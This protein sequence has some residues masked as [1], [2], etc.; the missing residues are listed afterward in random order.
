MHVTMWPIRNSDMLRFFYLQLQLAAE[1]KKS[2]KSPKSGGK[3]KQL[4]GE[5]KPKPKKAT[6]SKPKKVLTPEEIVAKQ[7]KAEKAA[8]LTPEQVLA[9]QLKAQKAAARRIANPKF[10]LT[11]GKREELVSDVYALVP[12]D[13][14][15]R[16]LPSGPLPTTTEAYLVHRRKFPV[17]S[18]FILATMAVYLVSQ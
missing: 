4:T 11:L 16:Y 17:M 10:K 14:M 1:K 12:F 7:L 2:P 13:R 6:R 3:R 18:V 9:K 8:M 5:E 15:Y